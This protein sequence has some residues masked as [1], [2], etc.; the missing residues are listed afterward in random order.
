MPALNFKKQFV[1][2]IKLGNKNQTI[3][4]TRKQPIRI[5]DPLYLYTGMRTQHC[6]LIAQSK[7]TSVMPI[8]ISNFEMRVN[9]V[10][11][12]PIDMEFFA[13]SDGF[14]SYVEMLHFFESTYGLPF[15]GEVISW[16]PVNTLINKTK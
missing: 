2:K 11:V 6:E 1:E 12:D 3:R 9:G 7:C 15:D 5:G 10:G 16:V 8:H 14:S 4:Q 13:K